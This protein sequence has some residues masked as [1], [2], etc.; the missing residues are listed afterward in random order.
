MTILFWT[1]LISFRDLLL[2]KLGLFWS[3]ILDKAA[4]QLSSK[5]EQ[6]PDFNMLYSCV[7]S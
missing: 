5:T 3:Q 1:K 7:V 6:Q 2:I 4:V